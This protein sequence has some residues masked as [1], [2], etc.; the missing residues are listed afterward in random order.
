MPEQ[1]NRIFRRSKAEY[2]VQKCQTVIYIQRSGKDC[3]PVL[4]KE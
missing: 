2:T 1:M 4:I 3:L